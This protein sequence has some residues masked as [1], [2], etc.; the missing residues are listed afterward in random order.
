VAVLTAE[1]ITGL[2]AHVLIVGQGVMPRDRMQ[3]VRGW[4]DPDWDRAAAGLRAR[5][6]LDV[7]D[8]LT[9]EGHDLRTRV[10]ARTDRLAVAP[11]VHLGGEGT[12]RLHDLVRPLAL[13]IVDE[14][15]LPIPNPIGVPRP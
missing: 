1:G 10:E 11:Y 2:E 5:N 6:L 7:H 3:A 12:Q 4:S 13:R 8:E 9:D 15:G 14:G